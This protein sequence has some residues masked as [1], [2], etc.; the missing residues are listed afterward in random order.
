VFQYLIFVLFLFFFNLFWW[1][2]ISVNTLHWTTLSTNINFLVHYFRS[3]PYSA[4]SWGSTSNLFKSLP[5]QLS[6]PHPIVP[7]HT[8]FID[9]FFFKKYLRGWECWGSY[10]LLP[11]KLSFYLEE[12]GFLVKT[13]LGLVTFFLF[14]RNTII[15]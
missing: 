7:L 8:T 14:L 13:S 5:G 1:K 4:I 6:Y 9:F 12:G 15:L 10:W 3:T 11:F 2:N